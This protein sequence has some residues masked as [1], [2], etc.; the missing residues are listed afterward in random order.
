MILC[1]HHCEPP[2]RHPGCHAQCNIYQKAKKEHDAQ[3]A[4]EAKRLR[5]E[6][7]YIGC[8]LECV[9]QYH[10]RTGLKKNY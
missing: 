7:D 4:A 6:H 9:A 2:I 10:K 5:A 3:K 1:C 8:K